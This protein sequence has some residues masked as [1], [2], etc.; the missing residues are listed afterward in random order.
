MKTGK[1]ESQALWLIIIPFMQLGKEL[2]RIRK[3]KMT[4][5]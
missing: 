1:R 2:G 5:K 3:R 4:K